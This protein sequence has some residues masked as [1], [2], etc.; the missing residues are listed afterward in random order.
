MEFIRKENQAK[1]KVKDAIILGGNYKDES[2]YEA[3]RVIIYGGKFG[4]CCFT[5]AKEVTIMGGEFGDSCFL[6]GYDIKVIGGEFGENTFYNAEYIRGYSNGRI[7]S[8][9]EVKNCKLIIK[10]LEKVIYE[11]YKSNINN[12]YI[13]YVKGNTHIK[14]HVI[15]ISEEIFNSFYMPS[16]DYLGNRIDRVF[17][18][19][20]KKKEPLNNSLESFINLFK[21]F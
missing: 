3:K 2:F 5:G 4:D 8:I 1:G 19:V 9:S 21:I 16:V 17:D 7:N 15:K 13:L 12:T 18:K 6:K 14:N 20:F 11:N 10:S